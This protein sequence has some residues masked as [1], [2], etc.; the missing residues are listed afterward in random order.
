ME[1]EVK[2]VV[3]A[4]AGCGTRRAFGTEG[5]FDGVVWEL[6]LGEVFGCSASLVLVIVR[7]RK[8]CWIGKALSSGEIVKGDRAVDRLRRSKH[9]TPEIV[10]AALA[11]FLAFAET[12][13]HEDSQYYEENQAK[14]AGADDEC[15]CCA[16]EVMLTQNWCES[17]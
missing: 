17:W 8:A 6:S 5:T 14:N 1:E 3:I 15:N 11:G 12:A 4:Q 16:G 13:A 9:A 2:S 10:D 7:I